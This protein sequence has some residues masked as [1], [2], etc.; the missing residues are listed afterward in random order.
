MAVWL[1]EQSRVIV[2]GMTGSEG[3]KHT[4]RMLASGTNIVGGVTPGKG[5]QLVDFDGAKV[6]VFNSVGEAMAETNADT[7]VVFVPPKFAKG[8]VLEAVDAG[9]GLAVVIT[10]GIPV[11]DSTAFW[12]HAGAK[13]FQLRFVPVS[14]PLSRGIFATCFVELDAPIDGG[15]LATL[16]DESYAREPFT[17]RPKKRLPEVVAVAG[18]N[19]IEVGFAVGPA[20]D[21]KRTVTC[22][23]AIDNL[24]KGGAGQAIQNMNL[25]LG[26]DERASLEDVGNWP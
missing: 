16:F 7:T 1:T 14:A 26:C 11:H 4:R 3:S 15:R 18:S 17:R 6:P 12:A 9:I 20:S 19:F 21:G 10:E 22:F 24:I 13:G 25:V 2:Q 8:A 23:S 5:G